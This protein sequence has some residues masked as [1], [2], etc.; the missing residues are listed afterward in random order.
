MSGAAVAWLA[1]NAILLLLLVAVLFGRASGPRQTRY[2]AVALLSIVGLGVA[3]AVFVPALP[4]GWTTVLMEGRSIR[5]F[6]QLYGKGAHVGVGFDLLA[7]ALTGQDARTLSALVRT[8]V[9]LA[10][11]NAI[12]LFWLAWHVLRAW[13]AAL[14]VAALYAANLNTLHA[15]LSE[16]PAMLWTAYFWIGCIAGA[17]V[18]DPQPARPWRRAL[19]LA[20]LALAAGLAALLRR[21]LLVIGLPAVALASA[22]AFGWSGVVERL[23]ARGAAALRA[24][25]SGP[26][27]RLLLVA[28]VLG[29]AHMRPWIG[30]ISYLL[31]GIDPFLWTFLWLPLKLAVFLPVGFVALFL[32][33]T[34]HGLRHWASF[35]LLPLS[36]LVLYKVYASATQG[37]L[38]NFRYMTFLTPVAFF[39]ALFGYR[40]LIEWAARWQWPPW[41]QRPALLLLA[42]GLAVWQP[43]GTRELFGRH[44]HL[45][46][47][48][49]AEPL[50]GRNQ[51]SEVRYLLDVV[52][53]YP[54]C[55]LLAKSPY[56]DTVSTT[57]PRYR[58]VA[59]GAPLPRPLEQPHNGEAPETLARALLPDAPCVLFYRSLDC[60][61]TETDGCIP[62]LRGRQPIE[63]LAL[64]NLPYSDIRSYGA[65]RAELHLGLYPVLWPGHAAEQARLAP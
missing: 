30:H 65:H 22:H 45:P 55:A 38:E 16:T 29:L 4:I 33:G 11:L 12:T 62:E 46:G 36:L 51:Q 17:A 5:N 9:C 52:R 28:A 40:E 34:I 57:T 59:F 60:N 2:V 13:W 27:W 18:I 1:A 47:M 32:L 10:V 23:A 54:T 19:A 21:E 31:D 61:L 63:E 3:L 26:L 50:L 39:M 43:L 37:A 53:R 56:A 25:F 42:L 48:T 15:A 8:N 20:C 49:A 41:W 7:D 44:Q 58:W 6:G 35:L 64:E 14:A 24:L